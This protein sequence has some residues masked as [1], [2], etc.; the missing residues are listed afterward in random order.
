MQSLAFPALF[1]YGDGDV[2][3]RDRISFASLIDLNRYLLKHCINNE[4]NN[5][6]AYPFAKY[7]R[8]MH[9]AQNTAERHRLNGQ[10]DACLK[11]KTADNNLT[12][13]QLRNI[14]NEGGTEFNALLGRMQKFNANL[15]GSNAYFF[16]KRSEL[17]ALIE[18][19]GMRTIWFTLSAADNHWLD[20]SKL[21]RGEKPIP[22]FENEFEKAKW[23][24]KLVRDNPHIVD[25]YFTNRVKELLMTF[26][27]KNGLE[28]D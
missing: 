26:L 18:Q 5:E 11:K 14:A 17:E 25:A 16:K 20:L 4:I 1:P 23:R 8:W 19:E 22:T 27:K 10:R 9:W 6:C 3:D 21:I 2:T 7:D 12:E 24:R 13:N 28:Y 15:V